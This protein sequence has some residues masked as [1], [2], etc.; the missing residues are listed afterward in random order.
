MCRVGSEGWVLV[1]F[2]VDP[3]HASTPYSSPEL[4]DSRTSHLEGSSSSFVG[5]SCS[6]HL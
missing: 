1:V 4:S 2:H 6:C 3:A 5:T